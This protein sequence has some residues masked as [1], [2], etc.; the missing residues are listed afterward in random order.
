MDGFVLQRI[1]ERLVKLSVYL[2][3][4]AA[5]LFPAK[6]LLYWLIARSYD[7]RTLH[8]PTLLLATI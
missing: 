7:L 4:R 2:D 6:N 1:S 8:G 3:T 5:I